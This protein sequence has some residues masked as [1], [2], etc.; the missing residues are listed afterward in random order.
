MKRKLLLCSFLILLSGGS[1]FADTEQTVTVGGSVV[2]KFVS[3]LTFSGDNVTMLFDDGTSQ[4]E[5]ISQ[6]SISLTYDALSIGHTVDVDKNVGDGRIYN[7]NGQYVGNSAN[8]L[9]K[10]VYI[11]N[12]KKIVVK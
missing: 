1:A 5:D 8:N 10:G 6:V 12:G 3:T 4:T 2:G 11:I 9:Q 7:I